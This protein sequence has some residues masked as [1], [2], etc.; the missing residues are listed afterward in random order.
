MVTQTTSTERTPIARPSEHR[1]TPRGYGKQDEISLLEILTVLAERKRVIFLFTA[2]F[3]CLAVIVSF[4]LPKWYTATVTLLPPQQN[5][6]LSAALASQLGSMG[7]IAALAGGSLGIRNQNEMFVGM[8]KGRTVEDAMVKKFGLMDEYHAKYPS[9]ARKRFER[10]T[11]IDGSGKDGLIHISVEARNPDRAAQLANGY[12]DQFQKLTEHLAMT[13]AGQRRLFFE[14]QLQ[15][16]KDNLATAEEA[17]KR[18]E[19][20]TGLIQL[21]SQARALIESAAMLRA[22][23]AAKEVQIQSMQTFATSENAQLIQA[24]KE[25]GGLRTQVAKLGGTEDGADAGLLVPKG[26]VPQAGLEY[27]RKLRDVKYNETIFEILARQFEAAKLDEA[28]QGAV[29]QVV[30][31]AVAPDKRSSPKRAIIV[32]VS[33]AFGFLIGLCVVLVQSALLKIKTDPDAAEQIDRFTHAL[34]FRRTG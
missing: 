12:V 24:E 28:K 13:E 26:R 32:L 3:A 29:I 22:Q 1:A 21:D 16:S 4:L 2:A 23:I 33:T 18:T 30:D 31:A 14:H 11:T 8:L 9:D 34:S 5:S 15:E 27:V 6:S 7:S 25:L 17:L 19:Q 10:H 20:Q